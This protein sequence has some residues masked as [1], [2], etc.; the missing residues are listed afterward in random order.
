MLR[1]DVAG[2]SGFSRGERK[3]RKNRAA[4]SIL[5]G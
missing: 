5:E 2:I 3:V 4:D 1:L